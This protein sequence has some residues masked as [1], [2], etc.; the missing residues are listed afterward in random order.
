MCP[1]QGEIR[2][3]PFFSW[4]PQKLKVRI[5]NWAVKKKPSLVGYTDAPAINW[6]TPWR[7]ERLLKNAGFVRVYGTWDVLR[8]EEVG[9]KKMILKIIRSNILTKIVADVFVPGCLYVAIKEPQPP[10]M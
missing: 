10:K 6:F 2:F 9:R 4:Y 5:M 8:D 1:L 3:F 7:A